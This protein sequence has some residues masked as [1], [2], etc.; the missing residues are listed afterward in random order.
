MIL[1]PQRLNALKQVATQVEA[2]LRSTSLNLDGGCDAARHRTGMLPAGLIPNITESPRKRQTT[3]RRRKRRVAAAIRAWRIWVERTLTRKDT[4][5][6][7]WLRVERPQQRHAGMKWLASTRIH[8]RAF[9][10]A[11]LSP[12]V[13]GLVTR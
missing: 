8:L 13:H 10:G 6:R 4:C 1:L 7:R 9:C 12:P 11:S 3:K 5:Q 2:N